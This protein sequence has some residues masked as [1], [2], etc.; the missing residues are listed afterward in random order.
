MTITFTQS[1]WDELWED[2]QSQTIPAEIDSC[3]ILEYL[4]DCVG[5]GY[6]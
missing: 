6:S 5:S 4:P 1:D 3:D 2:T